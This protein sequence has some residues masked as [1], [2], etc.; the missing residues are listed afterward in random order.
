MIGSEVLRWVTLS[1]THPVE[2]ECIAKGK[3]HK[4]YEFGCKV[5]LMITSHFKQRT[6]GCCGSLANIEDKH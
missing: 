2:V 5:T 1:L 4:R 3:T 6:A